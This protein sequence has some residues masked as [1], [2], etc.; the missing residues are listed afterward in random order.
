M[1]PFFQGMRPI[2][3]NRYQ[4]SE[5]STSTEINDIC[6]STAKLAKTTSAKSRK[7]LREAW[8]LFLDEGQ[9]THRTLVSSRWCSWS[10]GWLDAQPSEGLAPSPRQ[11]EGVVY[12]ILCLT[13]LTVRHRGDHEQ[14]H[15]RRPNESRHCCQARQTCSN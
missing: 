13:R 9:Y 7:E 4:C 2:K 10:D 14:T 1:N 15:G 8:V 3:V 5:N 11:A 12:T 6:S